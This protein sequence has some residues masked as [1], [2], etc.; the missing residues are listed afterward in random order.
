[1]MALEPASRLRGMVVWVLAPRS[2]GVQ[3]QPP[4]LAVL[5]E[6]LMV[7]LMRRMPRSSRAADVAREIVDRAEPRAVVLR[8]H[9]VHESTRTA[10]LPPEV[11]TMIEMVLPWYPSD[12]LRAGRRGRRR[13]YG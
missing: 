11:R 13:A 4:R 5:D 1:M 7:A 10:R 12:G 9:D 2:S 8:K 3:L 6:A